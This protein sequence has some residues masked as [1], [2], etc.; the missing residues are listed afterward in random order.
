MRRAIR[1]LEITRVSTTHVITITLLP[2]WTIHGILSAA[3]KRGLVVPTSLSIILA[4]RVRGLKLLTHLCQL[5]DNEGDTKDT[6]SHAVVSL[7][8][9]AR[10]IITKLT[11]FLPLVRSVRSPRM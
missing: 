5:H 4:I 11:V 7:N 1:I 10:R 3:M 8:C 6:V 2:G 9:S